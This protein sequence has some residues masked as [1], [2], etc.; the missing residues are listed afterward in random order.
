[1]GSGE[2]V[3]M[4]ECEKEINT[5]QSLA[6]GDNMNKRERAREGIFKCRDG[7]RQEGNGAQSIYGSCE[8]EM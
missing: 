8:G 2:M 3:R 7:E 5:W 4:G 6:T 1:M